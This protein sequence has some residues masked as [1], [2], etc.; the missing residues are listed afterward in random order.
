MELAPLARAL[1]QFFAGLDAGQRR[2]A[3]TP[4][5]LAAEQMTG[6]QR[7]ALAAAVE[8]ERGWRAA[9]AHAAAERPHFSAEAYR[10]EPRP[11]RRRG[12]PPI[13]AVGLRLRFTDDRNTV[14]CHYAVVLEEEP[15]R[16]GG[17]A[18][19][20]GPPATTSDEPGGG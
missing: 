17:A 10:L 11:R 15:P 12:A 3:L 18:R 19:A 7:A 4:E 13:A 8:R 14:P 2:A 5:G 6:A 1:L 16:R 20:A 9:A